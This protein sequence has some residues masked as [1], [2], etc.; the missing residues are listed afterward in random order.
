MPKFILRWAINGDKAQLEMD[1]AKEAVQK[2]QEVMAD[3][4]EDISITNPEGET[5][6]IDYFTLV[7]K[8]MDRDQ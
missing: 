2:A 6:E 1:T 5:F 8:D 4:A 7:T 3:G